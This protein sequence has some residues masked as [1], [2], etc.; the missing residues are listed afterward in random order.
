M[1]LYHLSSQI[2]KA[3]TADWNLEGMLV[4]G[5]VESGSEKELPESIMIIQSK[6]VFLY[7]IYLFKF[8][9]IHLEHA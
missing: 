2:L 7:F 3:V 4:H 6:Y 5:G 1:C 9:V 8:Q